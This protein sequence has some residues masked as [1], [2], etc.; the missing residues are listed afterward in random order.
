[1]A[2]T[3]LSLT[4]GTFCVACQALFSFAAAKVP[5]AGLQKGER[6]K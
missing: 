5:L 2:E 4:S 6:Q 3:T 1:M